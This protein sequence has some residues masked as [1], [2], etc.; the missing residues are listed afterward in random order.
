MMAILHIETFMTFDFNP[1]LISRLTTA[2]IWTESNVGVSYI[3]I[4]SITVLFM[5]SFAD[6]MQTV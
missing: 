2:P 3:L 1:S 4:M 5:E 6:F